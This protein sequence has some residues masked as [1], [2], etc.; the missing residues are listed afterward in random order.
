M[1]NWKGYRKKESSVSG[2]RRHRDESVDFRSEILPVTCGEVKGMLHKKKL[3][4]GGFHGLI[5][6]SGVKEWQE[7]IEL[8]IIKEMRTHCGLRE[9]ERDP[10]DDIFTL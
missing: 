7:V 5:Y 3:K 10:K 2:S 1:C 6:S 8:P 4:Q 9:G